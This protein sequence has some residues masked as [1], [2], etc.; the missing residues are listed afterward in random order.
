LLASDTN[1]SETRRRVIRD[2][3]QQ[4]IDQ[5]AERQR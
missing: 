5:L 2:S 3:A 4:K 1:D